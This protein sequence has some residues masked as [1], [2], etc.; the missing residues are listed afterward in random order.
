MNHQ[1]A[2]ISL[3]G[4][5]V[6]PLQSC[7][8]SSDPSYPMQTALTRPYFGLRLLNLKLPFTLNL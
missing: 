3:V 8:C 7:G 2:M 4:C 1:A 6:L 5:V